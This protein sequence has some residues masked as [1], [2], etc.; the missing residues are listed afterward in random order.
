MTNSCW[1]SKLITLISVPG[2]A[3][4]D[5]VL[6]DI[7]QEPVGPCRCFVTDSCKLFLYIANLDCD[8]TA[9]LGVLRNLELSANK[10]ASWLHSNEIRLL[11]GGEGNILNTPFTL[12]F[13]SLSVG[14]GL[15]TGIDAQL[16]CS[17]QALPHNHWS[18]FL[19]QPD[20]EWMFI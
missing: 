5:P 11:L 17:G 14:A 8:C 20:S 1:V 7:L 12:Q 18:L 4:Q 10:G 19:L 3:W 9:L 13:W 15:Y 16:L 6:E 2:S